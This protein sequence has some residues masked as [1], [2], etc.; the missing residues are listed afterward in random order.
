M[1]KTNFCR[2]PAKE[3]QKRL[4]EIIYGI[5]QP[6]KIAKLTGIPESTIY[7]W[8]ANPDAVPFHSL[9]VLV[10]KLKLTQ[11]EAAYLLTGRR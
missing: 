10:D 6:K 1:S 4:L 3:R 8:R 7:S 2:D 11:E 5:R 9:C